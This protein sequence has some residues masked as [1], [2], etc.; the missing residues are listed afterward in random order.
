MF[1]SDAVIHAAADLHVVFDDDSDGFDSRRIT[2]AQ[3]V[4][5]DQVEADA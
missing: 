2:T 4:P 5:A 3:L 1:V